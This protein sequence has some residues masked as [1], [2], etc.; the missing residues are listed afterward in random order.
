M[1]RPFSDGCEEAAPRRF[2]PPAPGQCKAKSPPA[3]VLRA[4]ML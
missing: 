1:P 4:K 3:A 2:V